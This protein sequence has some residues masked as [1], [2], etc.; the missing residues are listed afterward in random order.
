MERFWKRLQ[1]MFLMAVWD[2]TGRQ[3]LPVHG[4]DGQISHY[5][6]APEA[7]RIFNDDVEIEITTGSWGVKNETL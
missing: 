6:L 1:Q 2:E 3:Y 5:A 7:L 4:Y